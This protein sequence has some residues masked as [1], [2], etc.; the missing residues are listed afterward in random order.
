MIE[1]INF[2]PRL[3]TSA[4]HTWSQIRMRFRTLWVHDGHPQAKVVAP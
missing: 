2:W 4:F 3:S 1:N